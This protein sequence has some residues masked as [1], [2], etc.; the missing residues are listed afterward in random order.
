[1]T[2]KYTIVIE[3]EDTFHVAKCL[4]LGITSQ[5]NTYGTALDNIKEAI[6]LYVKEN[7]R[8]KTK[9]IVLATIEVAKGGSAKVVR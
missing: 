3:K 9:H 4:E 6:E 2:K 5:G 8:A 7:P 1:M